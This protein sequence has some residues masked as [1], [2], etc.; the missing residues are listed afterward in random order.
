MGFSTSH[1]FKILTSKQQQKRFQ[2]SS[3]FQLPKWQLSVVVY[4]IS[5]KQLLYKSCLPFC[6]CAEHQTIDNSVSEQWPQRAKGV[7]GCRT[8][9]LAGKPQNT[10]TVIQT[11]L[12]SQVL[13]PAGVEQRYNKK[14][15][16][17]EK[18]DRVMETLAANFLDS[19]WILCKCFIFTVG[20]SN[21][22][23]KKD[24][25]MRGF[26]LKL[27]ILIKMSWAYIS[28]KWIIIVKGFC[29][30]H[31]SA[32]YCHLVESATEIKS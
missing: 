14:H 31:Q 26:I 8:A 9:G 13:T 2:H 15:W 1:T 4:T 7:R 18:Q 25:N 23:K 12:F 21:V 10:C 22:V 29:L 11:L 5:S 24:L 6:W 27:F 16:K 19:R 3:L 30:L 32:P 17:A 20:T 28:F